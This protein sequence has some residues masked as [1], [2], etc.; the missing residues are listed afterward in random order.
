MLYLKH[1]RLS[2]S[3]QAAIRRFERR[4]G[5]VYET[6]R[7]WEQFAARRQFWSYLP[8]EGCVAEC[9]GASAYEREDLERAICALPPRSARELR[10]LV[11]DLDE[12]ILARR[13]GPN[14]WTDGWWRTI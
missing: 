4:P 8:G 7:F 2:G 13:I 11:R 3:T 14:L 10:A 5:Q 12:H 6:L 9:C 1:P